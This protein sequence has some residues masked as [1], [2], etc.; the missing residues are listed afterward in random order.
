LITSLFGGP[1]KLNMTKILKHPLFHWSTFL[2][3]IAIVLYAYFRPLPP[4]DLFEHSDNL[5]HIVAFLALGLTARL[6]LPAVKGM[7]FWPT[8][9]AMAP[10]F[11]YL[12]GAFRPLRIY[13]EYDVYANLVGV[14][15]AMLITRLFAEVLARKS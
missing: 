8:I 2:L 6:A 4:E 10:L 11:E 12:Q 9:I 14:L 5:G 15:L 13:N 1:K 3:S 7:V